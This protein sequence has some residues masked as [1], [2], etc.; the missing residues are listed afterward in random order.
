MCVGNQHTHTHPTTNIAGWKIPTNLEG[1]FQDFDGDE[2]MGY[3]MLVSGRVMGFL[4]SFFHS[5]GT[6]RHSKSTSLAGTANSPASVRKINNAPAT[7]AR[8]LG[9]KEP[10]TNGNPRMLSIVVPPKK[11]EDPI[12][13]QLLQT[14]NCFWQISA[15]IVCPNSIWWKSFT[16]DTY[17]DISPG[18]KKTLKTIRQTYNVYTYNCKYM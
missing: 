10:D 5:K 14:R 8:K 18:L 17:I 9:W 1:I 7:S 16:K 15:D 11:V 2:F 3:V 12:G 4:N 13:V 6:E